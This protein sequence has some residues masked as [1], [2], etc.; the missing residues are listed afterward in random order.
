[1]NY[2]SSLHFASL[3]V[4]N[5]IFLVFTVAAA[6][7]ILLARGRSEHFLRLGESALCRL[8]QHRRLVLLLLFFGVIILRI[9]ILHLVRVSVPKIHDEAS[10]LLMGDTFA[11]GR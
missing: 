1:M 8:A 2:L 6:G 11:H 5:P 10:Y 7:A 3:Q 4:V 9:A